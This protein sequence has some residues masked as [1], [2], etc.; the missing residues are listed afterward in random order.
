MGPAQPPRFG[1]PADTSQ[2]PPGDGRGTP[3]WVIVLVVCAV[4]CTLVLVLQFVVRPAVE[5]V[6]YRR[7]Q[8]NWQQQLR[9]CEQ[10]NGTL[11]C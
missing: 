4:V 3:R 2:P 6:E 10:R 5:G 9:Q 1:P 11:A 8:Q 7:Q